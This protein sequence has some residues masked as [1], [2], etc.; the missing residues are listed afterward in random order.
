MQISHEELAGRITASSF[1]VV[2]PST[3]DRFGTLGEAMLQ[4]MDLEINRQAAMIAYLSD[5]QLLFYMVL[6][7]LP[8]VL[9]LRPAKPGI[10][11][12]PQMP[13]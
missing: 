8:L 12:T 1:T 13:D 4:V 5:F 6:A 11:P 3:A 10:D 9:I 2:D 7:F